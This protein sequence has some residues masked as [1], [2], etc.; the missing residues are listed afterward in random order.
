MSDNY[1]STYFQNIPPLIVDISTKIGQ[2]IALFNPPDYPVETTKKETKAKTHKRLPRVILVS[3]TVVETTF[4]IGT[5]RDGLYID[6][7]RQQTYRGLYKLLEKIM[8]D[9][10]EHKVKMLPPVERRLTKNY[11]Y[12]IE[13]YYRM[14]ITNVLVTPE[15]EPIFSRSLLPDGVLSEFDIELD[16]DRPLAYNPFDIEL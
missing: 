2:I 11:G 12:R 14:E 5:E 7:K 4:G 10:V 15:L 9:G 13:T 16:D 8:E 3:G 1:D 6:R